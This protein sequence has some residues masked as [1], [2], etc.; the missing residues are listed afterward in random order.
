[1]VDNRAGASGVLAPTSCQGQASGYTLLYLSPNEQAIA[2]AIGMTVGYT[3]EK[4]FATITHFC[5]VLLCLW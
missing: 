4:D 5:A 1:M 2:Q 3:A